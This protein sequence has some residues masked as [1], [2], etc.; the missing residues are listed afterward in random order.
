MHQMI[1]GMRTAGSACI[2]ARLVGF[3]SFTE[4]IGFVMVDGVLT[5]DALVSGTHGIELC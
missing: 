1:G 3:N 2:V 5:R 4:G